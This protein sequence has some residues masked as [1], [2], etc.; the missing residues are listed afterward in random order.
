MLGHG[1]HRVVMSGAIAGCASRSGITI[2][3]SDAA[4]VTFPEFQN[5]LRSAGGVI[6]EI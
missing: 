3:G 2:R 4:A 5:L 1:D 6:E